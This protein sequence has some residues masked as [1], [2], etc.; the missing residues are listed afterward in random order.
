MDKPFAG[1]I[2]MVNIISG[3]D[4]LAFR[5]ARCLKCSNF[6]YEPKQEPEKERDVSRT[7]R[8]FRYCKGS[9][10]PG[11]KTLLLTRRLPPGGFLERRTTVESASSRAAGAQRL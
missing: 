2:V 1:Q 9:G 5:A 3:N 10:G 11:F 7:F 6:E 4:Y 8:L